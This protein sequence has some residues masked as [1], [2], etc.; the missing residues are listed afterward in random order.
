[1]SPEELYQ[2]EKI[3]LVEQYPKLFGPQL[4]LAYKYQSL[5]LASK[6]GC[7]EFSGTQFLLRNYTE[8]RWD[9]RLVIDDVS[10]IPK[11]TEVSLKVL[12]INM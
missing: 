9:K 3:T 2:L 7:R 11:Y 4:M 12:Y 8:L 1:M 6:G 5:P 10:N